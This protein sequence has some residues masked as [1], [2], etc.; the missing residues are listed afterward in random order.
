MIACKYLSIL[1]LSISI[2]ILSCEPVW[3]SLVLVFVFLV[4]YL[5]HC[6][7][8]ARGIDFRILPKRNWSLKFY[9][10][11]STI[12]RPKMW[13]VFWG[14][15]LLR[16]NVTTCIGSTNIYR[17][18]RKILATSKSPP[19]RYDHRYTLSTC[20]SL[21]LIEEIRFIL[22]FSTLPPALQRHSHSSRID[23]QLQIVYMQCGP[24]PYHFM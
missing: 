23:I 8:S 20:V 7:S 16:L 21:T 24:V 10:A 2:S 14:R 15:H 3:L 12:I 22:L 17:D 19:I 13:N 1:P 6:M 9:S 5:D 4:A 18:N 11:S